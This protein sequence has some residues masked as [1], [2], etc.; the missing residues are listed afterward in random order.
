[1]RPR[2]YLLT[3]A[4]A[5]VLLAAA[6]VVLFGNASAA[7]ELPPPPADVPLASEPGPPGHGDEP[8]GA[9]AVDGGPATQ[10]AVAEPGVF[11]PSQGR[12]TTGW[13]S[14]IIAGDIPLTASVMHQIQS[15]SV[16]VDELRNVR[17]GDK[18][19]FRKV[20]PVRLGIGTPTF[21]VT[22]VPFSDYGYVVRVHSPGLNGGQATVNITRDKPYV[23]DVKLPITPGSPYSVLLRDQD[24]APVAFT[25]VCLVPYQEPLGRPTFRGTTDNYGSVVFE[26]VLAGDYQV[27]VGPA[28]QPLMPATLVNVQPGA[29]LRTGSVIQPQGST[30]VVP[31]G[32]PLTTKVT[33]RGG[34]P[35]QGARV[36]VRATDRGRL[37]ELEGLT[38]VRGMVVFAN[39]LPGQW[40][41][42]VSLQDYERRLQ[43]LTITEGQAPPEQNFELIRLR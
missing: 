24:R 23:D 26:N 35:I 37:L 39:V 17:A 1:M 29:Y 38:D 41:I 2:D 36:Q 31:R 43:V 12:N 27:Y 7:G 16:V 33:N 13:T 10:V 40:E 30:I 21:E 5:L 20:V 3:A 42:D 32:M 4:G 28:G 8:G 14:G 6:A 15:I 11:H 18:A 9:V 34:Y 25:D 22:D 19:P